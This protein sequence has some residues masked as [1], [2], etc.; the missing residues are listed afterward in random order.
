[1]RTTLT[2]DPDVAAALERLRRA[3][4]RSFKALVNELLRRGLEGLAR[5]RR[6]RGA[7]YRTRGADLG[8][9]RL[10]SLDNVADVLAVAEG[11]PFR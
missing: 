10:G 1:M 7:P 2:L 11:E 6:P 9:C 4:P 3:G 5:E 8:R